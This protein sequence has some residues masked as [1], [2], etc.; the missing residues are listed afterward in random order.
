MGQPLKVWK[1]K[2][3][4]KGHQHRVAVNRVHERPCGSNRGSVNELGMYLDI[5]SNHREMGVELARRFA[6]PLNM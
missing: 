6:L 3:G 5:P 1:Q 4:P 2:L